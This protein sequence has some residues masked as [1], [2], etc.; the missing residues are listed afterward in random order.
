MSLSFEQ[1]LSKARMPGVDKSLVREVQVKATGANIH[2]TAQHLMI[3]CCSDP[4]KDKALHDQAEKK[5]RMFVA[6]GVISVLLMLEDLAVIP[7]LV[8]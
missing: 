8:M 6:G 1:R 2:K 7:V 4:K 3:Y 5:L